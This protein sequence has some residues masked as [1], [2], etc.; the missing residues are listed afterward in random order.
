MKYIDLPTKFVAGTIILPDKGEV[1]IGAKVTLTGVGGTQESITNGWGDF[2]FDKLAE[3]TPFTLTIEL[4]GY[5]V[6]EM[7]VKT[8]KDVSLG[9]IALEK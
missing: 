3:N 9:D 7:K 1:A 8:Q 4:D 2:E 5:A 6:K